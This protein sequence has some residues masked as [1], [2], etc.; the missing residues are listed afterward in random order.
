[1]ATASSPWLSRPD[2]T[3]VLINRP[4]EV[5]IETTA[6][7]MSREPADQLTEQ[8][9]QRLARQIAAASHQGVNREQPLLSAT[10]PDGSRVQVV[11][12]PATR[13]GLALA[14]GM[15]WGLTTIVI[16]GSRLTRVSPE[17]MLFYQVTVSTVTLPVLSLVLHEQWVW[18]WSAFGSTS[19]L[20]QTVVG[21]FASY[22]TWM[23]L[24]GHYPATRIS[25]FVFLTPVFA[26]VAG[27]GFVL[28]GAFMAL[29]NGRWGIP[30]IPAQVL[31]TGVVL[32]WS[33]GANRFWTF[34]PV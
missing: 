7:V 8:A 14:A 22:L 31:T 30:Y 4:G 27:V 3:D 24:L 26:L 10:L 12:P 5:W 33:F 23:W 21:A 2:V 1:M 19:M 6:G 34:R 18:S 32:L 20:V 28:T 11:S 15:F 29:F 17:K 9:L 13:G 25:A 16:R